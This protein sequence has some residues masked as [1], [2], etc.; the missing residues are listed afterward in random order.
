M[1]KINILTASIAVV[2]GLLVGCSQQHDNE[3]QRTHT[4]V[5]GITIIERVSEEGSGEGWFYLVRKRI[6]AL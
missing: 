1:R 4:P 2:T 6:T 5:E 3:M